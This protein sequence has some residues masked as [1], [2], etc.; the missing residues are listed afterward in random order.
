MGYKELELF[1]KEN[2]GNYVFYYLD[3]LEY[4]DDSNEVS[5]EWKIAHESP[6][7]LI[8]KNKI[9]FYNTS[10]EGITNEKI[11]KQLNN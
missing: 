4:R 7:V 5:K 9:L 3:I 11:K 6:Q 2:N 10:H 1:T 8:I